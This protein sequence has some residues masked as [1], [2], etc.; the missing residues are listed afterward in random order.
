MGRFTTIAAA[1][2]TLALGTAFVAGCGGDDEDDAA[3]TTQ[4][5]PPPAA[6]A[7]PTETGGAAAGESAGE[8]V[9]VGIENITFVPAR[10]TAKVGQRIVWTNNEAVPH[11]VTATD[12]A[13][14]E[15][16]TLNEDDTFEFTPTAAGTIDYVCTIHQG[17]TGSIEVT[18]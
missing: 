9:A 6:E 12:G 15:S 13:D 2:L 4:A 10:I 8:A 18:E 11:D 3:A 14:F 1:C 5:T 16:D 17:Q 7:P